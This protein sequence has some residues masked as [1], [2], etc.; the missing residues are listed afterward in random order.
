MSAIGTEPSFGSNS[1][2]PQNQLEQRFQSTL[3]CNI[4]QPPKC[5]AIQFS[6]S[7][8]NKATSKVRLEVN[9]VDEERSL[10]WAEKAL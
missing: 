8:L 7:T 5:I 6:E 3:V 1:F 4:C 2:M 9:Y 10:N